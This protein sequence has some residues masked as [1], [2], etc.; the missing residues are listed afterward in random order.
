MEILGA[1]FSLGFIIGVLEEH[2]GNNTII[3]NLCS[4]AK[5]Y[6]DE[7][8]ISEMPGSEAGLLF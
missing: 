4:A 6:D 3:N 5:G 1:T 8:L 2:L 7:N